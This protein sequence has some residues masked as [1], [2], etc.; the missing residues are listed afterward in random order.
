MNKQTLIV[1]DGLDGSGKATQTK[2]LAAYFTQHGIK[3]RMVSFPNY[4]SEAS[5]LVKMYLNGE[6]GTDPNDVGCFAA[7]SFY[8]VDRFASFKKD[9][10]KDY[11]SGTVILCDRYTTSNAI[12]QMAKL[13]QQEWESYLNWL[14][15]YEFV[16]LKLPKPDLVLYLDMSPEVSQKL[17]MQRYAGD[18]TKKDIHEKNQWYLKCCREAAFYAASCLDWKIITCYEDDEPLSEQSILQKIIHAIKEETSIL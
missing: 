16:K 10:E 17:L 3:N 4:Q 12:H 18:E 14:Y 9:W 11:R 6:F 8:A 7:S 1:I 13:P 5:C 15:D 2:L